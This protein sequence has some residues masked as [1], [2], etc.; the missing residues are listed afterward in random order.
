MAN[1]TSLKITGMAELIDKIRL[2]P[3]ELQKKIEKTALRKALEPLQRAAIAKTPI[4]TGELVSSYKISTRTQKGDLTARLTATAP[5][6]HLIEY[7]HRMVRGDRVVGFAPPKP[8]LRPALDET[9]Q[10]IIEI[11]AKEVEAAF[12]AMEVK[13]RD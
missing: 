1:T 5:H 7:G 4:D 12:Q 3:I 8:F 13:A 2:L 10:E 6:A 11:A 9:A